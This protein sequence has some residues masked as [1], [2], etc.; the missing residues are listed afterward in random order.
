MAQPAPRIGI[1]GTGLAGSVLAAE[2]SRWASVT[3]LERGPAV[4]AYP[5]RVVSS[6]R[7]FGLYPSFCYGLGG[8][9]NLW[10]GGMIAMTP[11]EYG[12]HWPAAVRDDLGRW[13]DAFFERLYGRDRLE[14]WKALRQGQKD[15]DL[16]VDYLFRPVEAHHAARS[17]SFRLV[18]LRLGHRVTAL[19]EAADRVVVDGTVG[20]QAFS[21]AFD[22]VVVAAGGLNSPLI[23]KA[24]GLGGEQVGHNLTDHPMGFVA[25]VTR[26]PGSKTF[27]A[28]K[29]LP[30]AEGVLKMRDEETGLWFS[31]Y[32]RPTSTPEI[33]SDP[34][35]DSFKVL[36]SAGRLQQYVQAML[37]LD[38][39]D[40]RSQVMAHLFRRKRTGEHAYVLVVAQQEGVGQGS[41]E[42]AGPE[43]LRVRWTVSDAV[44][45][46]LKRSMARL[47]D[48][49][50][51]DLKV[52]P[53]DLRDRLWS[54]AH[55]SGTCRMAPSPADGVVDTDLKVHGSARVFV[56]DGSVLPATGVS[57]TGLTIGGLSLRLA[58]HLRH[59]A[60]ETRPATA[61]GATPA[62]ILVTG[63]AETLGRVILPTLDRAG[64]G[65][66]AVADRDPL[67]AGLSPPP[68]AL[69]NI[70]NDAGSVEGNVAL[71]Q[72]IAR[73]ADAAGIGTV[74]MPMSFSTLV[75]PA[76]AAGDPAAFN[77][78]F[79][80][81]LEDP[82]SLGKF[83]SEK[84][85]LDWQ[86]AKPGR[87]LVLL[88]LPTV[89]GPNSDWTR[90]IAGYRPG[91]RLHVPRIDP[92]FAV[93]EAAVGEAVL[94][95]V[96]NRPD[97]VV[98]RAVLTHA[99]SL[100]DAIALDRGAATVHE[101]TLPKRARRLLETSMQQRKVGRLV[102]I[103][104]RITDRVLRLVRDEAIVPIAPDYLGLFSAQ[105]RID[106]DVF[107]R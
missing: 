90:A 28:I 36:G 5:D 91:L 40:F 53:G 72:R 96:R 30:E 34:Y 52:A 37:K 75:T 87:S 106:P 22:H 67:P 21:L 7:P 58:D 12:P 13:Q 17:D 101:V 73:E 44:V 54:A 94:E 4:P 104:Q 51:A 26:R 3:V 24:S 46:G 31:F 43:G 80:S 64:L 2:L 82:Y 6:E 71:Q 16:L 63:A 84:V 56:C 93:S 62:E 103:G 81:N 10:H 23:L 76:P 15:Q 41:V 35:A 98:R 89:L 48:W 42:P 85:W 105:S 86:K 18:D 50:D 25:K 45:A 11:S 70:A 49:L 77:L 33:T 79:S 55:H 100:A 60:L 38:D 69:L 95:S 20:G 8:T 32:L 88:Y 107:N 97:G 57:N 66:A 59:A 83:E 29:R 74:V 27:D 68:T 9:T 99:G 14:A 65:W 78:G 102:S 92:F 1:I 39:A 19:R 61:R 47:S